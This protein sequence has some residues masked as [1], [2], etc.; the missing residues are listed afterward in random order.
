M[1]ESQVLD[2]GLKGRKRIYDDIDA[3]QGSRA[4]AAI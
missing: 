2:R 1:V 4:V 3:L